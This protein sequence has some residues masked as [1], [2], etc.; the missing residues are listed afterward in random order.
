MNIGVIILSYD[1]WANSLG[2]RIREFPFSNGKRTL[3]FSFRMSRDQLLLGLKIPIC[4]ES[5]EN[6]G[7]CS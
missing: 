2:K 1:P 4:G 7:V 5:R 3:T 6:L